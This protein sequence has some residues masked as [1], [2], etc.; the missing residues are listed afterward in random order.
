M[1]N[2]PALG[3]VS[4]SVPAHGSLVLCCTLLLSCHSTTF[5]SSGG[6]TVV[7]VTDLGTIPHDP[8]ILGRDGAY[9]ALFQGNSVWIYGDTF[10]THPNAQGFSLIGDSWSYTAK[11][12]PAPGITGFQQPVDS[13]GSPAMIL[14]LTA[15]ELAY[16][17]QHNG[18]NCQAQPCGA[19]WALWPASIVTDPS[20][21]HA[22]IFYGVINA[23]PGDFNFQGYGS[24]VAT[25]A[26]LSAEPQR[27]ILSSPADPNHP[28]LIWGQNDPGFGSAALIVSGTLYAFGCGTPASGTDKGC[29]LARVDPAQA[30]TPSAWSYYAGNGTWSANVSDAATVFGASDILSVA[31]N[32]YLNQYVAVFSVPFSNVVLFRTA[33]QLEG[34][35]SNAA[36][37]FTAMA[38]SSGNVYD[39]HAHPEYDLN[40]GETFFVTYSRAT[41]AFTSEVRLVAVVVKRTSSQ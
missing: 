2:F 25:W 29:R 11:L 33:S 23:F 22:L 32:S 17:Q 13:S 28:D 26:G 41:G 3:S 1:P 20:S 4:W 18:S 7:S 14:P 9:S 5:P 8:H 30:Q 15:H 37:L 27:P 19:R 31:W 16:N 35:W 6:V 36:Y 21:G 34:P 10:L 38:P 12:N 39:A 24:S 40:G